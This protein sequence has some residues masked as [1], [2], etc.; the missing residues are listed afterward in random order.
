[1]NDLVYLLVVL[2]SFAL[3]TLLAAALARN[4]DTGGEER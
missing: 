3:L 2:A 4:A 1:M